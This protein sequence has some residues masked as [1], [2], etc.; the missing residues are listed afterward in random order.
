MSWAVVSP[1]S[2]AAQVSVVSNSSTVPEIPRAVS[3]LACS[4]GVEAEETIVL[5][6]VTDTG[7]VESSGRT[8]INAIF[9]SSLPVVV[10]V[11][12][13]ETIFRVFPS[14]ATPGGALKNP[15]SS[16]VTLLSFSSSVPSSSKSIKTCAPD[17]GPS[18]ILPSTASVT[19]TETVTDEVAPAWSS[20]YAP[21][22]R[23]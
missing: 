23:S 11:P 16:E 22:S 18:I 2:A 21:P 15:F 20:P 10:S 12:P 7:L 9:G 6:G 19:V 1:A 14:A 3:T 4:S 5:R 17:R 8:E 13:I